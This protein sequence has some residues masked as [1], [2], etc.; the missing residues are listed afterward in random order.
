MSKLSEKLEKLFSAVTFA[1]VGEFDTARE[2]LVEKKRVLLALRG[3][4]VDKHTL[5]YAMNMCK[6]I[7]AN[8]DILYGTQSGPIDPTVE[9]FM[10]ELQANDIKYSLIRKSGA[11]KQEILNFTNSNRDVLFVIIESIEDLEG[12]SVVKSKPTRKS[13]INLN[14]PLVVVK[15]DIVQAV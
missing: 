12:D 1:E 4:K 5:T 7:D 15:E 14:C 13:W 6:R 9:R 11:M 3:L 8:L 10:S 2:M